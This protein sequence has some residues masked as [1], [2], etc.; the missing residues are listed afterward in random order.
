MKR[1]LICAGLLCLPACQAPVVESSSNERYQPVRRLMEQAVTDG[2]IPAGIA[3]V[4][5]DGEE[6]WTAVAGEM[7]P[8]IPMR[9]DVI[10]PL[11]SVGKTFT[12]TAVMIL[13]EE[14]VLRLEDPVSRY[15]PEFA[16][17]VVEVRGEDGELRRVRAEGP[18]TVYHLLTHTGGLSVTGDE[19][20]ADWDAHVGRTTATHLARALVARPLFAQPGEA[21]LYGPTGAS[22][23]VL[24]AVVEIASGQTLEA[25]MSERI[26]EPLSLEDSHFYLPPEKA[27]RMPATY[28]RTD[29]GL[30]LD[31]AL[32]ED[33]PR[34][35]F[36]HGGGGVMSS[37]PDMLRF[38]RLFLEGGSVDG[39]RILKRETV[40]L[41][42]R[43]HVGDLAPET[44]RAQR[45]S[46]GF[47][48]AVKYAAG[49][50]EAGAPSRYGWVG[51]GFA[52]LWIDSQ[53]GLVAYFNCPL[54]PPGDH[55]L[56]DEFEE[57][58]Y[59]SLRGS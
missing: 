55:D 13:Y 1:I 47:G 10:L 22:Y 15:I 44:W 36:F 37:A 29:E 43:D 35:E 38:A 8:G 59:V 6:T 39:V 25:F 16:D 4:A 57:R 17:A 27:D 14:G 52:K 24:G 56:M 45:R 49:D 26:F 12:A 23:E 42:L 48:A 32:G 30:Q 3:A 9:S 40:D 18:I 21:F 20:W 51:G 50:V 54:T 46:W 41:M 34:S 2:R 5:L 11:A 19:F 28:R 53:R 31:R 7:A 33:F 58:V